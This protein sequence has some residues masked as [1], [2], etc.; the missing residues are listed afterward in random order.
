MTALHHA[1]P[2]EEI[3]LA[4]FQLGHRNQ[5]TAIGAPILI[6]SVIALGYYATLPRPALWWWLSW[7][8]LAA[9]YA[10]AMRLLTVRHLRSHAPDAAF[11]QRWRR[12]YFLQ[13]W[14]IG[15]GWGNLGVLFVPGAVLQNTVLIVIFLGVG[16]GAANTAGT[17]HLP[18]MAIT[19][20]TAIVFQLFHLSRGFG[21]DV[22]PMQVI[23]MLYLLVL[24]LSG[25]NIYNAMLETIV[26]R[27]ENAEVLKQKIAEAARAD[28]AN[29]DKSLF[30]AA[31]SHDLRQPVHALLLLVSALSRH[32]LDNAQR[33]LVAHI[34]E[35][36]EAINGLFN[37]LMELSRLESGHESART[38]SVVL[39][40]LLEEALRRHQLA[41]QEKG[42]A[43]R[44]RMAT[45][46]QGVWITTDPVLLARVIDNLL[47]NAVR[48]T[49]RGTVLL[50]LRRRGQGVAI[51]VVDTGIGIAEPDQARIFDPYVQ[52]G[53]AERD[54]SRGLGL[55]L[56]IVNKT[57]ALLG[58][59]ISLRSRPRRGSCFVLTLPGPILPASQATLPLAQTAG[60]AARLQ[61]RRV[62]LVEDDP[63][64][65]N[66]MRVVL[67]AWGAQI[68]TA[69]HAGECEQLL[70]Q[71]TFTPDCIICD[72][73]LPGSM[74]GVQ[75]LDTL[76]AR[77]P[78]A[79]AILQT[80]DTDPRL[81]ER[82]EEAGF[83]LLPKPVSGE[84]LA[85]VIGALF[86]A[87]AHGPAA[88]GLTT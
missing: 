52:V 21:D 17:H 41:A 54:R 72:F 44:L 11:V 50:T 1:V 22:L 88:Q 70:A 53:N 61:G 38:D 26:L 84:R 2:R 30:L 49:E 29:H 46:W 19:V 42:L 77:F 60:D 82:A 8:G 71:E 55:G 63:M 69:A 85:A 58:G 80:G 48:Y 23:L 5:I 14:L 59:Q 27:H 79:A 47:S 32:T 40:T 67:E 76:C 39:S 4:Q 73:R 78:H 10:A 7:M 34:R 3:A 37:A 28:K 33:T 9:C 51:A 66:A 18:A 57:A 24:M 86:P 16:L 74:N 68:R 81:A 83:L 87:P 65:V 20:I 62:L 75:L 25:R 31:A 6:P 64:V 13:I 36:G 43:L 56:A 15:I 35:A 45:R 12:H